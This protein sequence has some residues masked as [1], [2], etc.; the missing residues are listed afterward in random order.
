MTSICLVII[1]GPIIGK[2]L[3]KTEAFVKRAEV[4]LKLLGD[5]HPAIAMTIMGWIV[6]IPVFCD[7][8]CVILSSLKK[9]IGQKD[10]CERRHIVLSTIYRIVRNHTRSHDTVSHRCYD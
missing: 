6:S 8:G 3:E 9:I 10:R 2:I 5:R 7:S 1:F 4:V